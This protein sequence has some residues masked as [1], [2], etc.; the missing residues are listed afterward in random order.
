MNQIE[1]DIYFGDR[2]VNLEVA[3]AFSGAYQA[4]IDKKYEGLI[5]QGADGWIIHFKQTTILQGDDVAVI[6]I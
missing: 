4:W 1:I 3:R 6:M 5:M 2:P